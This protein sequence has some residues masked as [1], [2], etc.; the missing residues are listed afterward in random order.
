MNLQQF[1]NKVNESDI[2][3]VFNQRIGLFTE[4]MIPIDVEKKYYNSPG[5]IIFLSN[6]FI[7]AIDA[8]GNIKPMSN[9]VNDTIINKYFADRLLLYSKAL[10]QRHNICISELQE[11]KLKYNHKDK[12]GKKYFYHQTTDTIYSLDIGTFEWLICDLKLVYTMFENG[13]IIDTT[14][15]DRRLI[16]NSS[17]GRICLSEFGIFDKDLVKIKYNFGGY[18]THYYCTKNKQVYGT[19]HDT[20]H[21]YEV[22]A[23]Y[24]DD[25]VNNL[26]RYIK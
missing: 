6:G 8:N 4:K 25:I 18:D 16:T 5:E 13:Y 15:V 19:V 10:Q 3:S 9:K 21:T 20:G 23:K 12:I 2:D 22:P 7:Y 26:T 24:R 14:Q 11:L 1:H 17:V